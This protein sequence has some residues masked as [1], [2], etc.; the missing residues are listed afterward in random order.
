[1]TAL[2]REESVGSLN[3]S[4]EIIGLAKIVLIKSKGFAKVD[5]KRCTRLIKKYIRGFNV[6]MDYGD[7]I[8]KIVQSIN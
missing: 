2:G 6:S 3:G 7:C 4:G 5:K 1:L 8:M